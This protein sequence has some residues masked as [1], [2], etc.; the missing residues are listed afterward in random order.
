MHYTRNDKRAV[1]VLSLIL[2]GVGLTLVI[3]S[4]VSQLT[5]VDAE[6]G[7]I[8]QS[9]FLKRQIFGGAFVLCGTILHLALERERKREIDD[10]MAQLELEQELELEL[11]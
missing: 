11:G 3:T 10:A 9:F 1:N 7:S 8:V 4:F 2:L 5:V 6:T